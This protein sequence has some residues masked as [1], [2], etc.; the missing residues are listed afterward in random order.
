MNKAEVICGPELSQT[1]S[2]AGA[3]LRPDAD[4]SWAVYPAN[5]TPVAAGEPPVFRFPTG[6]R[7]IWKSRGALRARHDAG[8]DFAVEDA[9]GKPAMLEPYMGMISHTAVLRNDGAVFAHLHPTGNFSMAAQMFF[10]AKARKENGGGEKMAAGM[11]HSRMGHMDHMANAATGGAAVSAFSLPYEFPTAGDY[12][13]WVQFKTGGRVLTG[14][15][16]AAVAAE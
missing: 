4:D 2:S 10:E 16:D 11:D 3:A 7:L 1:N 6:E 14:V 5:L 12:R 9:A 8:F 15:F 13:I